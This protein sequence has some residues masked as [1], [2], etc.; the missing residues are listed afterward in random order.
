MRK[1]KSIIKVPVDIYKLLLV[2]LMFDAYA[3]LYIQTFPVTPF[4]IVSILFIIKGIIQRSKK[5]L[6]IHKRNTLLVL[7]LIYLFINFIFFGCQHITSFIQSVYFVVLCLLAFRREKR[8]KFNSYLELFQHLMTVMSI[9][10]IYQ[11]FGRLLKLPFAD[12]VISGHMVNGFNWTNA[13]NFFG[14]SF[15]RSN[16]VFREPS[17]F[18]QMLAISIILYVPEIINKEKSIKKYLLPMLLQIIALF[19]TFSGTG[20]FI[21]GIALILY[22]LLIPKTKSI[23]NRLLLFVFFGVIVISY[24]L[25]NTSIGDYL[26]FRMNELF[27][28]NRDASSGFVRFRSWIYVVKEAWDKNF[29]F[30]SGVGTGTDYV[31]KFAIQYYGMTLNGFAKVATELGIL[32][33]GLWVGYILTFIKKT[34]STVIDNKY[35]V[36]ACSMIPFM[37]MHETFS[38]NI[39]WTFLMLLNVKFDDVLYRGNI[40]EKNSDYN[41]YL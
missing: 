34:G 7:L 17:F 20:F 32:G 5:L 11:F 29:L 4:T 30:G 6:C 16:A 19:L 21:A 31:S 24:I 13:V 35:L 3:F 2:A 26:L 37:F 41:N 39:F 25:F 36:L 8:G 28:Y 23:W 18:G 9:Y 14:I 1:M 27:V 38:S 33:L 40:Y 22:F 15:Y 10:G 12:L